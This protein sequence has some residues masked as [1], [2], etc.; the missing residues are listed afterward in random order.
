MIETDEVFYEEKT[1]EIPEF[2]LQVPGEHILQDA[3]LVYA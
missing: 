1:L 2:D 3:K